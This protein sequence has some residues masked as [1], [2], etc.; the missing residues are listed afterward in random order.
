MEGKGMLFKKFAGID[1][2]DLEINCQDPDEII[3]IVQ[4]LEPTFG[5]IN[6]EDIKAPECFYIEEQLR[7]KMSIPVFHDDQ[8]G[9][10]I[11]ASSGFINA[12]KVSKRKIEDV[13]VV[14]NG[15]GAAA[16]ATV[17]LFLSL[18]V[19]S[20]NIL[21][22]DSK[23]VIST[24]RSDLSKYKLKVARNTSKTT[25]DEALDG[26]DAFVGVSVANILKP[27][28]LKKM[29]KNPIIFALANP[30]PEITPEL[31]YSVRDDVIMATGRSDYPN[32]VNNVLGFPYI[33]RGALDVKAT[34]INDEM[35]LAA[36]HAIASLAHEDVPEDVMAVYNHKGSFQFGK[37]YLIP[38]P[39]DQ[40]VLLKVA[41]AVAKAAMDSGVART[42]V[43]LAQYRE[44]IEELLGPARRILRNVRKQISVSNKIRKKPNIVITAAQDLRVLKAAKQVA[45]G[46]EVEI[47]LIGDENKILKQARNSNIHLAKEQIKIVDP[48]Q[49]PKLV[50]KF[51]QEIYELRKD[52]GLSLEQAKK[53]CLD[54]NYFAS[55]MVKHSL[56]HGLVGGIGC[57]YRDALRSVLHTVGS[58]KNQ[59]LAGTN[60]IIAKNKI[61]F[62]V[63][64]SVSLDPSS[65]EL[66][67]IAY[68]AALMSK[69][70][71]KEKP[72]IALLSFSSFATHD[73]PMNKKMAKAVEII[74]AK[75][76]EIEVDGEMAPDV[77]LNAQLRNNEFSFCKL[78]DDA[79][80]LV[81]PSLAAAN[82][83]YKLL[84]NLGGAYSLGPLLT[85]L[86]KP[87][88]ILARSATTE[89]IAGMVYLTAHQYTN[90]K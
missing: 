81:F 45:S 78:T 75:H 18:G 88:N 69:L 39:V 41:P 10:A 33:F 38:K 55:L 87:A 73:D 30:N 83:S 85:G 42:R 12:L 66:A 65:Q 4:S 36:V 11:I 67:E 9:T 56:A 74:R 47:T 40:R 21:V 27:A 60:L 89:E 7:K 50:E 62:F 49:E 22:C 44:N 70:Y 3:K 77:A 86:K 84:V 23:G 54:S 20:N 1:V 19:Q 68:E 71:T 43:D 79:N 35:K 28:M 16:L 17:E 57:K 31:A 82:I 14:F 58:K 90:S 76:P 32:Q 29:N 8:H 25:L 61:K 46:G 24:T 15:A 5:G 52:K 34:V 64:C 51:T 53:L 2:F 63:D 6:L 37:D 26:A 72:R 80:I 48:Q 13:K 59:I